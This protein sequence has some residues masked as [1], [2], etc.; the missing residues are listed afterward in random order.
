MTKIKAFF[1][2]LLLMVL[3]ALGIHGVFSH[4]SLK[5]DK[6]MIGA[7]TSSYKDLSYNWVSDNLTEP[8]IMPVLGSSEFNHGLGQPYHPF[9]LFN[10]KESD[11][12]IMNIGGPFNQTLFHTVFLGAAE[13]QMKLRKVVFLAS[14]TWF[15]RGGVSKESYGLR[16]S[17]GEYIAFMEN[18]NIPKSI[19]E[20]V[21]KRSEKLLADDTGKIKDVRLIDRV[22]LSGKA[23]P[24]SKLR[25]NVLKM[26]T[27]DTDIVTTKTAMAIREKTGKGTGRKKKSSAK[28]PEDPKSPMMW[29]RAGERGSAGKSG[30]FVNWNVLEQYAERRDPRHS[31]K[32]DFFMDDHE[33]G[34]LYKTQYKK[35]K[36][37]HSKTRWDKSPEFTDLAYFL[38]LCRARGIKA[39]VIVLPVNGYWYDY[40]GMTAKRRDDFEKK[41]A[42]VCDKYG[43]EVASLSKY[44]YD[45]YITM[46][47]VHPWG[48]GWIKINEQ[49]YRFYR[50]K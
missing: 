49:I 2:A 11:V 38:K 10:A 35:L 14:P 25:Y 8:D 22:N 36:G 45:K 26:Y 12:K 42:G 1:T 32:N 19:K 31:N 24:V 16:F 27:F 15:Q 7:W 43:A 48:K 5:D 18:D 37:Y 17:T 3:F 29:E 41:I 6:D 46:D 4:M 40:T 21:A 34:K 47:A 23:G 39:E 28:Y 9:S 50:E 13:P 30:Y 33:W 20:Y 44:D